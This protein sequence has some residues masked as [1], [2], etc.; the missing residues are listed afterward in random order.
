MAGS[1]VG[2]AVGRKDVH[3]WTGGRP[4][5]CHAVAAAR[6]CQHEGHALAERAVESPPLYLYWPAFTPLF[7]ITIFTLHPEMWRV[8]KTDEKYS[9]RSGTFSLKLNDA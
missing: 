9:T 3:L 7:H 8:H 2:V 6:L 1:L 5:S 4:E